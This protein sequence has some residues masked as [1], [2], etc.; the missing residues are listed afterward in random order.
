[1][2]N[3]RGK[4]RH[5]E[6][7]SILKVEMDEVWHGWRDDDLDTVDTVKPGDDSL[8]QIFLAVLGATDRLQH[9]VEL[10]HTSGNHAERIARTAHDAHKVVVV[11]WSYVMQTRLRTHAKPTHTSNRCILLP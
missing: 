4:T 9:V 1:M 3:R 2:K 7:C 11:C 6:I 10:I 8:P 5:L